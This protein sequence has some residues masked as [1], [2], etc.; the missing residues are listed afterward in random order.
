MRHADFIE[1]YNAPVASADA[2]RPMLEWSRRGEG[3]L[4]ALQGQVGRRLRGRRLAYVDSHLPWQRSG[5]RYADALALHEARPD[6]VFFSMYAMW[7]PFPTP[8]LPLAQFPRLAPSLGITDVYGVFLLFMG[9]FWGCIAIRRG[10]HIQY[11]GST[12]A[13]GWQSRSPH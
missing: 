1:Q 6:T 2:P 4:R 11:R 3:Q 10:H 7:D 9:A 8:V 13:R 12:S 5:F